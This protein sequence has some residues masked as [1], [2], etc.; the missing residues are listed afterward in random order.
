[1]QNASLPA[2]PR[3]A[4]LELR[5]PHH[6]GLHSPGSRVPRPLE[7]R[8]V[9]PP[10][11]D[12]GAED[13]LHKPPNRTDKDHEL[14]RH[15]RRGRRREPGTVMRARHAGLREGQSRGLGAGDHEISRGEET[16]SMRF[17]HNLIPTHTT[18]CIEENS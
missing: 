13:M 10:E 16:V 11:H 2:L 12:D 7:R 8:E 6:Q 9:E 17:A 1:M 18:T 15:R 5:F 3:A 14:L 4:L